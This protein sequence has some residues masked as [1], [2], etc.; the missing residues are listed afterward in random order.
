LYGPPEPPPPVTVIEPSHCP[1]IASTVM[2][3]A[4]IELPSPIVTL[5]FAEQPFASVIIT[6]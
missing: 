2:M 4:V 3:P 1:H 5:P 6:V